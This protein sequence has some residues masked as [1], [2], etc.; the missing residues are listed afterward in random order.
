[1]WWLLVLT[2]AAVIIAVAIITYRAVHNYLDRKKKIANAKTAV[3]IREKL[4]SGEYRVIGGVFD[5]KKEVLD[6]QIWEG[7]EIDEEL[8]EEFGRRNKLTYTC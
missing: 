8:Q 6:A 4:N 2:A 7:K 5:K 1:M 3:L